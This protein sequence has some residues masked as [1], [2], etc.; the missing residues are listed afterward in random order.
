MIEELSGKILADPG[1]RSALRRTLRYPPEHPQA[2]TAHRI[3]AR[4]VPRDAD[5]ATEWAF[6]AIAAM[7]AAQPRKARDNIDNNEAEKETKP[8]SLGVSIGQAVERGVLKEDSA[9]SRLHLL[10]RQQLGLPHLPS[11]NFLLQCL[12]LPSVLLLRRALLLLDSGE[13][14]SPLGV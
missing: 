2:R 3:V 8:T 11:V 6:Y 5:A 14:L 9:E 13:L 1:N 10:C 12:H 4:F 7:M